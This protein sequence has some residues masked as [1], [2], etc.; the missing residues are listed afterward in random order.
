MRGPG[1]AAVDTRSQG[2]HPPALACGRAA[3]QP[4]SQAA[5]PW[6]FAPFDS[7]SRRDL[8]H[9]F[10]LSMPQRK[11]HQN[12]HKAHWSKTPKAANAKLGLNASTD[13]SPSRNTT[14]ASH[15]Q[16]LSGYLLCQG[17]N[18]R[19]NSNAANYAKHNQD[20][21]RS[22]MKCMGE[23]TQPSAPPV[24]QGKEAEEASGSTPAGRKMVWPGCCTTSSGRS[25]GGRCGYT[26]EPGRA[27]P[28]REGKI[29]QSIL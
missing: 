2:R 26:C 8:Q 11:A 20:L 7:S 25:S 4:G 16:P 21:S 14:T 28:S 3:C 18:S 15:K 24:R 10:M 12:R 6:E 19:K 9:K 27:G 23:V 29:L 17:K 5:W 1:H 22:G 13:G